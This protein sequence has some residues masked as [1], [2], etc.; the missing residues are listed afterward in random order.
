MIGKLNTALKLMEGSQG[1][2]SLSS[3]SLLLTLCNSSMHNFHR[4]KRTRSVRESWKWIPP[5]VTD[6][7]TA[8]EEE[9]LQ[10]ESEEIDVSESEDSE[11]L[12]DLEMNASEVSPASPP[13]QKGEYATHYY[14]DWSSEINPEELRI[15]EKKGY[16]SILYLGEA[17]LISVPLP[18]EVIPQNEKR[19]ILF[20]FR[21]QAF[22]LQ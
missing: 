11:E 10:S 15:R 12:H 3:P 20:R 1:Y 7:V 22:L 21:G 17:S 2:Y 5:Q 13:Q 19:V 16:N 9:N 14:R 8:P 6:V 18:T 4:A